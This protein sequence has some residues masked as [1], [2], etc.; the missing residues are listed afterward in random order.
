MLEF[1]IVPFVNALLFLYEFI[2][3]NFGLAIIIFTI[4]LRLATFPFTKKQ[5]ESSQKMQEMQQSKEWQK[6]QKKYKNDKE[7]LAQ[8]QMSLYKEMGVS[9]FSSCLPSLIQMI[10]IIPVFFSVS[11]TLV[12]TPLQM[13]QLRSD[14]ISS[15]SSAFSK[16][17][18]LN[19]QWWWIKDLGQPERWDGLSHII[20][21]SFPILGAGIPILTILVVITSFLQSKMITPT[22][23]GPDDQ[24]A[25]M[26]R[27]MTY[28]MPI[29]FAFIAYSYSA[30]LA[31]YFVVSNL[32]T[33]IQYI[34]TGRVDIRNLFSSGKK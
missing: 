26:S 1:L 9:P 17:I 22:S 13:L 4:V 2:G 31:L 11:R 8:E 30:G 34:L 3:E 25:A 20:P 33:I 19:S 5:L 24:S 32:V 12:S 27:S 7:K 14:L 18:P 23:S 15:Y 29:M 21:E 6:I 10:I 16:L 28:M